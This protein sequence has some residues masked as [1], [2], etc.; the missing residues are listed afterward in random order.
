MLPIYWLIPTPAILQILQA[1]VTASAVIPLW[2]L[3]GLH[4]FDNRQRTFLCALLML[5]PA[6]GGGCYFDLHENCFLTPLIL[7]FFYGIDRR[8]RVITAIAA[9]LTLMV[10]EDAAVYAAVIGLW[11]LVNRRKAILVFRVMVRWLM[12]IS[13]V[14][15]V[16]RLVRFYEIQSIP[17][18]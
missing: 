2:K 7:W 12:A 1:A 14:G 13:I 10:K 9:F 3:A 16:E 18:N 8:N 5:L 4:D 15:V 6:Y 11:L 17:V